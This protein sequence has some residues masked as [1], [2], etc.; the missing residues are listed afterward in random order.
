[1]KTIVWVRHYP[2][3]TG[4]IETVAV[5][6][7]GDQVGLVEID[8]F[9]VGGKTAH[10]KGPG[11]AEALTL[12]CVNLLKF[13]CGIFP[14]VKP[15]DAGLGL[16]SGGK[17]CG[18]DICSGAGKP[19]NPL[20][21]GQGHADAGVGGVDLAREQRPSGEEVAAFSQQVAYFEQPAASVPSVLGG[22]TDFAD[23]S[24]GHDQ[25]VR[26]VTAARTIRLGHCG[27]RKEKD[28]GKG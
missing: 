6:G 7:G 19:L 8:V 28:E 10:K 27:G 24:V 1:M 5:L 14:L 12:I 16:G 3:F 21:V 15:D 22:D 26:G 23:C 18:D 9:G 20:G 17:S 4:D 25:C 11:N 13:G 2:L